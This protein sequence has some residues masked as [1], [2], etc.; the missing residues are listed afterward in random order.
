MPK[1]RLCEFCD[2]PLPEGARSNQ[3][4]CNADCRRGRVRSTEVLEAVAALADD[5]EMGD[6]EAGLE[7]ALTEADA[8]KRLTPLDAGTVAAIRVLARKIDE[9]Q[10]R[11]DYCFEWAE[12]WVE[13]MRMAEDDPDYDG[14][15][16]PSPP[17]PPPMD[18]VS[19][20]TFLKY[21]ESLGLTPAGR[22]RIPGEKAKG[23]TGGGNLVGLQGGVPRPAS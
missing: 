17:K 2:E 16:P 8:K 5:G 22:G 18:N 15:P 6:V 7:E 13:W 21:A 11:W 4:F 23:G 20:P 3:K 14:G 9:E 12:R 10:A 19:L 1:R